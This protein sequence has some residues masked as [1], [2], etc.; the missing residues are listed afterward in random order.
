[1][2]KYFHDLLITLHKYPLAT[3]QDIFKFAY[4]SFF[5]N[6]HLLDNVF[7]HDEI[8]TNIINESL[9]SES[10]DISFDYLGSEWVRV[11]LGSRT[12][13][14]GF[15]KMLTKSF[16]E[17]AECYTESQAMSFK[18][19]L[20]ETVNRISALG[21]A[22][23]KALDL[24]TDWENLGYPAISHSQKYKDEYNPHYRVIHVSKLLE[25]KEYL[26]IFSKFNEIITNG[27]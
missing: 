2:E 24:I 10:I 3:I 23:D 14:D 1:M 4:Q 13:D 22:P 16:I 8:L 26:K 7:S 11:N 19:F 15:L 18:T 17:S 12:I 27:D 9:V 6:S 25:I 5:G 21:F 20:E